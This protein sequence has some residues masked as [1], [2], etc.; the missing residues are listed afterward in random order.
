VDDSEELTAELEETLDQSTVILE[1]QVKAAD[2]ANKLVEKKITAAEVATQASVIA[3]SA[4]VAAS[5][6]AKSLPRKI[7]KEIKAP[8]VVGR[9]DA[10]INIGGLK[11]GQ[12]I[13]V[14]VK[15]N[16]K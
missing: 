1:K 7:A 3:K 10:V 6:A 8:A 9:C 14:S 5:K 12:K 16:I 4:A 11:P 13:R 2:T 15:V